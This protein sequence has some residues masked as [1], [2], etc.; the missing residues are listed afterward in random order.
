MTTLSQFTPAETLLLSEGTFPTLR[1]LLKLTFID[2]FFKQ[3]IKTESSLGP[4]FKDLETGQEKYV[5]P[6][7]NYYTY[8]PLPHEMAFLQ[9]FEKYPSTKLLFRHF[10]QLAYKNVGGKNRYIRLLCNSNAVQGYVTQHFFQKITG[11]CS[12]TPEGKTVQQK[13]NAELNEL[14]TTLPGLIEN[15]KDEAIAIL[16]KI[17]G[18]VFLLVNIPFDKWDAIDKELMMQVNGTVKTDRN[19]MAGCSGGGCSGCSTWNSY[20]DYSN[21]FDSGC[22]GSDGNAGCG[23]TSGCSSGDSGGDSG[24]SGGG[25]CGGGD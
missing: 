7:M 13:L 9:P 5:V 3:V 15:S 24:C 22:G 4:E 20:S 6:G 8:S 19:T 18:N 16:K 2:L 11:R 23:G 12:L 1:Q 17:K 14:E 10:V 25:G 21:S